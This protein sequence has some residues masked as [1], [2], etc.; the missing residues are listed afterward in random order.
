MRARLEQ[1][2]LKTFVK[3]SGGKG[4]HVVLPIAPTPW[5]E[6]KAFAERSRGR[7]RPTRRTADLHRGQGQRGGRIAIDISATPRG[8]RGRA[9]STRARPGAP[10]SVPVDWS[11][12]GALKSA[13]QYTVRNLMQRLTE[14]KKDP[15]A[16]IGRIKQALPKLK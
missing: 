16:G 12:L 1:I 3:T 2:K 7:W 6:A 9:Y 15:W 8:D 11:E 4:L 10:A 5:A 13:N 14:L